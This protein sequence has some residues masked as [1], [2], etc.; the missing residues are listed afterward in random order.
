M[1]LLDS[2]DRVEQVRF[3]GSGRGTAHIHGSDGGLVEQDYRTSRWSFG[4]SKMANAKVAHVSYAAVI[5]LRLSLACSNSE[6]GGC[7]EAGSRPQ[8]AASAWFVPL[9]HYGTPYT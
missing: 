7:A 9:H 3:P 5:C 4:V 1:Y 6:S 8:E 2:I